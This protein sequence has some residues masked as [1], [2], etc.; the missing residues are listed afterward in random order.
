MSRRNGPRMIWL[1]LA[2][3]MIIGVV[4]QLFVLVF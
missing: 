1:V 4:S 3:L 2:I